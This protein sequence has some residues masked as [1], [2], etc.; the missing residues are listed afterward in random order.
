MLLRN[1]PEAGIRAG[2]QH[3]ATLVDFNAD[4]TDV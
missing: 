4:K 3:F 2:A 1:F